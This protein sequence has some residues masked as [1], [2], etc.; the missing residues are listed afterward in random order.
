MPQ[1]VAEGVILKDEGVIQTIKEEAKEFLNKGPELWPKSMIDTKRY[2][3]TDTLDDFLG[4]QKR[5]EAIFI[6]NTLAELVSEFYLRT[7]KQW[8]GASKWLIRALKQFDPKF[9]Y[10]F[11]S[12]FDQF[13]RIGN[14]EAVVNLVDAVLEPYGGR[15]FHGFMSGEKKY[16]HKRH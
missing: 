2:F 4:C 9:A 16:E 8:I 11:V 15:F 12:A 5:E 1:M 10:D 14:K 7:N 6:A 3:I 13:Y